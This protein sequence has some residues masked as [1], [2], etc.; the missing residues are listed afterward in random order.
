M[1]ADRS[2]RELLSMLLSADVLHARHGTKTA[3]L[4]GTIP[5]FVGP[6]FHA[7]PWAEDIPYHRL[8][9]FIYIKWA[10]RYALSAMGFRVAHKC[11]HYIS[12]PVVDIRQ[13]PVRPHLQAYCVFHPR[14]C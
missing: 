7:M 4:T 9:I 2:Y 5:V 6:P 13:S 8:A 3:D 1:P 10:R 11:M 14:V 12:C